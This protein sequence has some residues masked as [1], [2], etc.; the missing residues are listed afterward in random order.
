MYLGCYED[1]PNNLEHKKE[2]YNDNSPQKLVALYFVLLIE[3][4]WTNFR[5]RDYCSQQGYL[6]YGLRSP[7]YCFCGNNYPSDSRMTDE[8]ACDKNCIGDPTFKCGGGSDGKINIY[9]VEVDGNLLA[10]VT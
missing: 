3:F 10:C 6:F 5:C 2:F 7:R 1:L 9:S 4:F 8:S